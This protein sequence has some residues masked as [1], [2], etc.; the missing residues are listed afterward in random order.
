MDTRMN[1]TIC[2]LL[3]KLS[4]INILDL[5]SRQNLPKFSYTSRHLRRASRT[6]PIILDMRSLSKSI[7]GD[8]S[9]FGAKLV[10][11]R[12][13]EMRMASYQFKGVND[14]RNGQYP[15]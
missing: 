11:S 2:R 4:I 6:N 10:I 3:H 5:A 13:L 14:L 7:N 1:H 8:P 9:L 15:D 12:W